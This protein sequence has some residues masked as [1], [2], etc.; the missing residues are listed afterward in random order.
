M[1]PSGVG[2][3]K[4]RRGIGRALCR[5]RGGPVPLAA[6]AQ[7]ARRTS[8]PRE[9]RLIRLLGVDRLDAAAPAG[10]V[11]LDQFLGRSAAGSGDREQIVEEMRLVLAGGVAAR[12]AMQPVA[13]DVEDFE[14][15]VAEAAAAMRG[16]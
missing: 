5:G 9:S 15:D 6:A 13:G 11:I 8:A 14:R 2:D 3:R 10:L 12:P 1:D 16:V 4:I 7:I